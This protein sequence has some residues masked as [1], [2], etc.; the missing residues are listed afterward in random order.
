MKLQDQVITI[1]QAKRLKELGIAQESFFRHQHNPE[2]IYRRES[3]TIDSGDFT[4]MDPGEW[5]AAFTV[6]ELGA[7]LPGSVAF[8]SKRGS[9]KIIRTGDYWEV[10]YS[11]QQSDFAMETGKT[12]AQARGEM[13]IYLLHCKLLPPEEANARLSK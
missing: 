8:G 9:L 4:V 2:T 3:Q 11:D 12:E 1:D 10:R 5:F 7:M 6:A 13:L